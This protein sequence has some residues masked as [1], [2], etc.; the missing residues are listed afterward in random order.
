MTQVTET[1]IFLSRS[2]SGMQLETFKQLYNLKTCSFFLVQA[3]E[4]RFP[5]CHLIP[6][7]VASDIVEEEKSEDGSTHRVQRRCAL[8]VDA[9]RLL[10]RVCMVLGMTRITFCLN[11]TLLI[12]VA[13]K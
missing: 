6:M 1:F 10:K 8:D 11:H 2:F 13:F 9:P 7:F 12:T 5:T 4:R 3:Y